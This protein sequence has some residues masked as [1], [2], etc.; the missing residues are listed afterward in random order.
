[1]NLELNRDT[2]R[3]REIAAAS[4]HYLPPVTF[5]Q[6]STPVKPEPEL[7]RS[8]G[9][10][11]DADAFRGSSP[12]LQSLLDSL[13]VNYGTESDLPEAEMGDS[14][15]RDNNEGS[16]E[17]VEMLTDVA[18][19]GE[20]TISLSGSVDRANGRAQREQLSQESEA[21]ARWADSDLKAA[22]NLY[23]R[24]EDAADSQGSHAARL[25][26]QKA[27]AA[28]SSARLHQ[29]MTRLIGKRLETAD[30]C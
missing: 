28:E 22:E 12:D 9:L 13:L 16:R 29:L 18:S 1:M 23:S 7:V 15:T 11:A 27:A 8:I 30:C 10:S 20:R 3:L 24:A 5:S 2:L 4:H 21:R 17:A 19:A 25:F 26:H 14:M 6:K